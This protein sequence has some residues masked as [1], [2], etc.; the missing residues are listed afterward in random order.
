MS[1]IEYL[2]TTTPSKPQTI[3][4][5]E[6]AGV[7]EIAGLYPGY[8]HTLGNALRRMLLSSVVGVGIINVRIKGVPH[9]FSTIDGILEDVLTIILRIKRIK[10]AAHDIEFPQ[11]I[12]LKKKGKGVVVAG[13]FETPSQ[14]TIINAD[15]PLAEITASN[16]AFEVEAEIDRGI[17]FQSRQD[18][19]DNPEVGI[20]TFDTAFSPVKRVS[21]SVE[22]MRVGNRTD[23][24]RLRISLETDGTIAPRAALDKSI[25]IMITQFEAMVGFQMKEQFDKAEQEAVSSVY[26]KDIDALKITKSVRT[27]LNKNDVDKVEELVKKGKQGV[28][29]IPGI[30]DK[31][32]DEI[33]HALAEHGIVLQ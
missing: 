8:G 24:N 31:A 18:R 26:S 21:Y 7:Y 23:Y 16:A 9:E 25:R 17:G 19:K 32:F 33:E 10:I 29:N 30:G 2:D 1:M 6:T 20:I 22:N 13:D 12:T 14:I 3:S 4:E 15:L 27:V 28:K 11:R 5:T